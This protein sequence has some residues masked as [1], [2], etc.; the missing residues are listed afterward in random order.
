MEINVLNILVTGCYIHCLNSK[1]RWLPLI[2]LIKSSVLLHVYLIQGKKLGSWN[3][4]WSESQT[5]S[6][7]IIVCTLSSTNVHKMSMFHLNAYNAWSRKAIHDLLFHIPYLVWFPDSSSAEGEKVSISALAQ[8][9]G[10]LIHFQGLNVI[11]QPLL[12][13][14]LYYS[15]IYLRYNKPITTRNSDIMAKCFL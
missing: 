11:S 12:Q 4:L 10:I 7:R 15:N 5:C 6:I 14:L 9:H 13:R 8:I 3:F 2:A 1:H